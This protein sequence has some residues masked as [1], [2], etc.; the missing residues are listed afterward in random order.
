MASKNQNSV[1]DVIHQ[2]ELLQTKL[3][4]EEQFKKNMNFFKQANVNIYN[5]FNAYE[6][7]EIWPIFSEEGYINLINGKS[8]QLVYPKNPREYSKEVVENFLENPWY[9][10]LNFGKGFQV[11]EEE[12]RSHV[13]SMN[14]L[15]NLIYSRETEM[16]K[17]VHHPK[18]IRFLVLKGIGLG[19][20]I[21]Y[22]IQSVDIHYLC[23]L[24]PNKDIFFASLH[25]ID[26]SK[27]SA[28]FNRKGYGLN[29]IFESNRKTCIDNLTAYMLG[30][31]VQNS[32]RFYE[33]DHLCSSAL[34]NL[35]NNVKEGIVESIKALGFF[36]DE[37]VGLAHS[38]Y[39]F[40]QH[41]PLLTK[42]SCT[43]DMPVF[44]CGNGPSLDKSKDFLLANRDKAIIISGGSTLSSLYKMGIKPDYHVENER[45]LAVHAWVESS[46]DK[47]YRRDIKFLALNT[48]HP[49]VMSE[50]DKIGVALKPNDLG[51]CY[52]LINEKNEKFLQLMSC[53]PTVSNTSFSFALAMGFKNIYLFGIDLGFSDEGEHHS[54]HSLYS[55][56]GKEF[57]EGNSIFEAHSNEN[58]NVKGNFK[59]QI[60]TTLTFDSSKQILE[61]LLEQHPD[62]K[63]YNTSEGAYIKGTVPMKLSDIP[64]LED[65]ENKAKVTDEIFNLNFSQDYETRHYQDDVVINAFQ[66]LQMSLNSLLELIREKVDT[67]EDARDKF[68]HINNLLMLMLK[69][70]KDMPMYF[71]LKGSVLSFTLLLSKILSVYEEKLALETYR[72]GLLIFER[73]VLEI[74]DKVQNHLLDHD[75]FKH[76]AMNIYLTPENE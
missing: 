22:L 6:A 56:I 71:L 75:H 27:L 48:I 43:F 8:K 32:S 34:D 66:Y 16:I 38:I 62:A 64:K 25:M 60:R 68:D 67:V 46:S 45:T 1:Q 49:K 17:N 19:Y 50:F 76:T 37:Q 18:S 11:D 42:N 5:S 20:Q 28:F 29:I 44:L 72:E 35:S 73:F 63:V 9:I 26:Y 7:K 74:K 47:A 15:L 40:K 10:D 13:L 54:S 65:I 59:E 53:N 69:N 21:E 57:Y 41:Y 2:A 55:K 33:F 3:V 4:M 39:N 12:D 51:T 14:E 24:E 31:G 61:L 36:D 30:I 58:Y 52:F 70:K 23:L